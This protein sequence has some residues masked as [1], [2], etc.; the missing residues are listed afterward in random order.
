MPAMREINAAV[1]QEH[2]GPFVTEKLF[3]E[4]PR[5]DEIVVRVVATGICQTDLGMRDGH[6]PSPLPVVL[7]HEGAGVV[8]ETGAD[9]TSL[10]PGDH[11]VLTYL[12]CGDCPPCRAD[13]PASCRAFTPLCFGGCRPDGTHAIHGPDG[14][15]VNDRFFGQSSFATHLVAN[16]RNAVRIEKDVPLDLVGPLGCGIMTGA[17]SI[18]N[19][20]K[21]GVGGSVAIFGAGSVGLSAVMAAKVAQ[22]GTIIA[23]DIVP[24][25]L[26]KAMELGATHVINAA[27]GDVAERIRAIM[28]D[29]VEGAF[30]TT[31]RFDV[32]QGAL[33]S[34]AQCGTLALVS[35]AQPGPLPVD[36][37]DLI[38]GCK[39]IR[40][41][42][43]GGGDPAAMIPEMIRLQQEG[44]FP[45]DKLITHYPFAQINEACAD[46]ASGKAIKAVLR[47]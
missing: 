18:W 34:L 45:F 38:P 29:G 41:V 23:V 32:I 31:G 8:V 10:E 13:E 30:D 37:M 36:L 44:L 39:T 24:S 22:A 19:V 16:Q 15:G 4:P 27:E 35:I 6:F 9:V 7:G 43:E 1:V 46:T 26:E 21:T 40:G 12:S 11:V 33:R 25:R 17:G 42:I 14:N 47:L 20:L 3:L 2:G 5:A 28:P